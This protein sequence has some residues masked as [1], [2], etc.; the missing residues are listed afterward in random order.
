[1]II[2]LYN[3]YHNTTEFIEGS[4]ESVKKENEEMLQITAENLA[5]N[6]VE[7]DWELY[8]KS[9]EEAFEATYRDIYEQLCSEFIYTIVKD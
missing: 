3:T 1:M 2:K 5:E 6:E 7:E 9:Y 4:L 8:Y